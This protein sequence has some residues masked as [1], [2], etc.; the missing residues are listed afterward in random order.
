MR[1]TRWKIGALAT[2]AVALAVLAATAAGAA[3]QA[4]RTSSDAVAPAGGAGAVRAHSG[5]PE[6]RV[7]P[8]KGVETDDM[9][10]AGT[11]MK[12]CMYHKGK[13]LGC[14]YFYANANPEIFKVC[15]VYADGRYVKGRI[16]FGGYVYE[17]AVAGAGKCVEWNPNIAEGTHVGIHTGVEGIGWTPY[18]Y[19]Y[20]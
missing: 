5:D 7:T 13:Y 12:D 17:L 18:E 9:S 4:D 20:A 2:G 19:G 1:N 3:T 11:Y 16:K 10:A 6:S 14:S 15:D 8:V